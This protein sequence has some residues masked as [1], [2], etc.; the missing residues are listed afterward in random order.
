M[1]EKKKLVSG[2]RE[3]GEA[4]GRMSRQARKRR[5]PVAFCTD[6]LPQ[7]LS[8]LRY[9][10]QTRLQ[11][12]SKAFRQAAIAS[13]V[14]TRP[15]HVLQLFD[16]AVSAGDVRVAESMLRPFI[17]WSLFERTHA[18]YL[19]KYVFLVRQDV[20][21]GGHLSDVF[22]AAEHTFRQKALRELAQCRRRKPGVGDT[23]HVQAILEASIKSAASS[24]AQTSTDSATSASTS[25]GTSASTGTASSADTSA[26]TVAGTGASTDVA[27]PGERT[28]ALVAAATAALECGR[29]V[30]AD[31]VPT[32]RATYSTTRL[33][34]ENTCLAAFFIGCRR[35]TREAGDLTRY[36]L[37]QD[38]ES[39]LAH[40]LLGSLTPET[41]ME[42]SYN[43]LSR[44]I[45]LAPDF[46]NA[47]YGL[48][49]VL[50][51]ARGEPCTWVDQLVNELFGTC[52][53]L[54]PKHHAAYKWMRCTSHTDQL[55][56]VLKACRM[57][58]TDVHAARYA[59]QMLR[60]VAATIS[61]SEHAARCLE[62][63]YRV[64]LTAT[65]MNPTGMCGAGWAELGNFY[66][67][68]RKDPAS[69]YSCYDA[70]EKCVTAGAALR[71]R[72]RAWKQTLLD[73]HYPQ[74]RAPR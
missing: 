43:L 40:W 6:A 18:P 50:Q 35:K 47:Y 70:C 53:A 11:V 42:A 17:G 36:A 10:E 21:P 65:R 69:A 32:V 58:P 71:E 59:S 2:A 20:L 66:V 15:T 19:S 9:D 1:H 57:H 27:W 29:A 24:G 38:P 25:T 34:V 26:G 49:I 14:L 73:T 62:V 23:D 12:C 44:S 54:D 28:D 68:V 55:R 41:S 5:R 72:A 67:Q 56:R 16:E 31:A 48:A 37:H 63:A 45:Q 7:V 8:F 52:L 30:D 22:C 64:L 13:R 39:A 51:S 33:A 4:K 74:R 3:G 46:A 61:N 60:H